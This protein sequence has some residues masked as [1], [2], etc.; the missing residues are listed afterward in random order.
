MAGSIV[1][2]KTDLGGGIT[3]NSIAWTADGSGNVNTSTFDI[4]RGRVLSAKMIPG[5]PTP[6]TGYAAK[7]LDPDGV[8]LLGGAGGNA[9]AAAGFVEPALGFASLFIPGYP[10]VT[11]TITGAGANAQGTLIVFIGP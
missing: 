8:D 2:A 4:R 11:P 9:A 1:V 7:L 3:Q 10:A 5:T 6:T